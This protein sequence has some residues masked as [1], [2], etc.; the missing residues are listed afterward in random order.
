M[1]NNDMLGKT[2]KCDRSYKFPEILKCFS[3]SLFMFAGRAGYKF[4]IE[5]IPLPSVSTVYKTIY[6]KEIII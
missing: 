5:N 4:L 1:L 3:A 2:D 6:S